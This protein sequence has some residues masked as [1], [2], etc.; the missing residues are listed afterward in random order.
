MMSWLHHKPAPRTHRDWSVRWPATAPLEVLAPSVARP[1]W[2]PTAESP[3]ARSS[4]FRL[5]YSPR[6]RV[7]VTVA[8]PSCNEGVLE[9]ALLR[10]MLACQSSAKRRLDYIT[11]HH[12]S[13]WYNLSSNKEADERGSCAS[14]SVDGLHLSERHRATPI[15]G[16]MVQIARRYFFDLHTPEPPSLTRS[17]AQSRLLDKV[18][19]AYSHLAPPVGIPSGPF[20]LEE[21]PPLLACM[22]NTAPGPDG[23]PFA[24]WKTLAS[25]IRSHNASCPLD[26]LPS[27]WSSFVDLANNVRSC[28]SSRCGFKDA[29]ISMFFKKGDPTLSRNY[30]PISSMNTDCKLYTNLV[31]NRLSPWAVCKLHDDQKGFVP[32]RHIT[33]HTRLAYKV[34]HLANITGT[35]GF[36]VSLDQAKAYNHV[37][38]SW[39]LCVM[40]R[41]GLPSDLCASVRDIIVG[42][43]SRV[44]INR[45]YSTAFSLQRGVRQGDLLSC[46][47]FNF[48]IEPLAMRL[49]AA[50]SGFLVHGLPPVKV[51]FYADDVN[52]FLSPSDSLAGVVS[53]L[54]ETSFAIGS[55]FNHDKTDVKPL[56]SPDFVQRCFSSQSLD[57]QLLPESYVL[58]P[59]APL[60]VLGVW[61]ASPDQASERWEQLYTHIRHLIRQWVSI[62][63]SLPNHVLIAKALLMSR[64]YYLLDGNSAPLPVLRRIS[65]S[66]LC[67]VCGPFSNSP[68]AL[69]Q[70]SLADGGLNCPSLES[71]RIAYD[72]K[73]LSDLISGPHSVPWRSWMYYDLSLSSF[74]SDALDPIHINPLLQQGHTHLTFLSDRLH[75]AFR[76]ACLVGLDLRSTFPSLVA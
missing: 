1:A 10:R 25:R 30:R 18:S 24:F 56:R 60:H 55:Q 51:L 13:E 76:S 27:F 52:L 14:I 34:A 5:V 35:S 20:I 37:D 23:I 6:T 54:D 2:V 41:M 62:G 48:S 50:L 28:G 49:R 9:R 57:G 68:Y 47:L 75:S 8:P 26:I 65:Q 66:I 63:A 31:N 16:E 19:A 21:T 32:G 74:S 39:L 73:F 71:R 40:S 72:L 64:C 44:Q 58:A 45:G 46:L 3:W 43:H 36:L 69:L 12:T 7:S 67:F 11:S 59:S 70:S 22:H 4:V 33:D 15:L 17:L 53:C 42:C 38:Q 61:V 29:N